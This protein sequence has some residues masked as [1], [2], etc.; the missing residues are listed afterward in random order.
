MSDVRGKEGR[1]HHGDL[2]R[3]MIQGA[4]E[5]MREGGVGALTLRAAARRAGVSPAAPYRHFADKSALLAAVAEQ[6]FHMLKDDMA[7][8]VKE[9]PKDPVAAFRSAAIAYVRFAVDNPA[10]FRV[11]FGPEV[12][13]H[14]SHPNL[15]VAA[16]ESM[17]QLNQLVA[18]CQEVKGMR[19]GPTTE[20]ALT[21]WSLMHG[22]A[23]LS[24]AG[25][26]PKKQAEILAERFGYWLFFG[27]R[28]L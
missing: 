10:H 7:K 8:L 25:Q 13:D 18:R 24:V 15:A 22:V 17:A 6:G 20:I 5:L 3:A 26:L 11:M 1:Y 2:K 14:S 23:S 19:E 9:Q 16:L 4:L 28:P 27:L 21:S 12:A